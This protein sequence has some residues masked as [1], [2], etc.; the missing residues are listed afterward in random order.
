M[1]AVGSRGTA[2]RG[3]PKPRPGPTARRSGY[4]VAAAVNAVLLYLVDVRP[5]WDAVPFLT[6]DTTL[7]LGAVN[8]SLVAGLRLDRAVA[9]EAPQGRIERAVG[10]PPEPAERLRE[11]PGQ[12]VAVHRLLLEEP[13]DR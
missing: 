4:V 12:L 1:T 7:V 6:A 5:G 10:D 8:A 9:L 3:P 2:R 13:Q 11:L